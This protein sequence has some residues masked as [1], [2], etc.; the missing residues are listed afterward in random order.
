M[1]NQTLE[2]SQLIGEFWTRLRIAVW[3]IDTAAHH[4]TDGG[5][6]LARLC[7]L[8]IA[9]QLPTGEDRI[10][11]AGE[12]RDAFPS[13]LPSPNRSIPRPPQDVF[14]KRAILRLQLLQ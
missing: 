6:D 1:G 7:I 11:A 12:D 10:R 13:R 3:E 9:G 8:G 5:L 2:P 4:A 14:R